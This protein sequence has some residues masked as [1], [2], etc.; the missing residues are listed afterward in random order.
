[1]PRTF[2]I[3]AVLAL[4]AA[5]WLGNI[6]WDYFDEGSIAHVSMRHQL[7]RLGS[8]MY[9]YH[10]TTGRWPARIDDLAATSLAHQNPV[11]RKSA[12]D[13]IVFLWPQDLKAEPKDNANVLLAYYPGGLYNKFG[14]MWVCWGDL[15]T[16]RLSDAAIKAHLSRNH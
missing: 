14:R 8:A 7:E 11:Y 9:E 4:V 5:I 3:V 6:V 16:E 12:T 10:T 15:R 2:K 1:M 13:A